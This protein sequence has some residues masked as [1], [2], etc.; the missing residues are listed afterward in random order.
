MNTPPIKLSPLHSALMKHSAQ[1]TEHRG[2]VVA[3]AYSTLEQELYA[4]RTRVAIAD[5][6]PNGKLIVEGAQAQTVMRATLAISDISVGTGMIL[7]GTGIYRLRDDQFFISTPPGEEDA[8]QGKLTQATAQSDAF[9]TITDLTHGKSELR[10]IG[11]DSRALLS[12]LCALDFH[13]SQFPDATAKQ[14]SVAK[15][16]ELIIRRDIDTIPAFTLIGSRSLGEYLWD[17][18]L[19]AGHE[20]D[21]RP[22]GQKALAVL[23]RTQK[24]GGSDP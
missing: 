1:R 6:T 11:P 23:E 18:I 10:L 3:E 16:T 4:A 15:T 9:V 19:E 7:S 22:I 8:L 13:P 12:K 24:P 17:V 14:T 2:W 21:L 20:F 5:T